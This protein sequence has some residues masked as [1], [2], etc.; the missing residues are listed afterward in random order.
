MSAQRPSVEGAEYWQEAA[1]GWARRQV[2]LREFTAPVSRWLVQ[3]LEPQPGQRL[4]ELAAGLGDAGFLAAELVG[5][6]GVVICSDQAQAMLDAAR[7]R[8]AELGIS[9][10]EFRVLDAEWIDLPLATVDAVLCRFGY[11]LTAD[12]GAALR[13]TRRVL[14]PGG[15]VALAVWD[16]IERNPWA[17]LPGSVLRERGLGSP[18]TPGAPGPFAL[19]DAERLRELLAQAGFQEIRLEAV[20]LEGA[21]PDFA[22]FWET[23]LDLS[24]S[25]HDAVLSQSE[26]QIAEIR[27]SV[28]ERLGPYTGAGGAIDVPGRALV[29]VAT[30]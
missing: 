17:L 12:P 7:A 28:A 29:A 2:F 16:A 18:P 22:A 30:A 5:P 11:M 24:R 3:A 23:A 14:R 8:A 4:L 13:E 26:A 1:P 9:N 15:R 25:F 20:Q 19:A 10:V 6:A 21:H 27:S